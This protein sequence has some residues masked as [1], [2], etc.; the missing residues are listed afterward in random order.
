MLD[1]LFVLLTPLIVVLALIY[2]I[3]LIPYGLINPEWHSQKL[4][5]KKVEEEDEE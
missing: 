2:S 5:I 4:R 1:R 3:S